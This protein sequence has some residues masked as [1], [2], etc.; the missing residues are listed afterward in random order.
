MNKQKFWYSQKTFED[1][2]KTN[3]NTKEYFIV[4]E[5]NKKHFKILE[6]QN[7]EMFIN[8]LL[9]KKKCYY[10]VFYKPKR[11]LYLDIDHNLNHKLNNQAIFFIGKEMIRLL[12][13]FY[14]THKSTSIHR[15]KTLQLK[16]FYIFN[17]SRNIEHK[18]FTFKLSLHIYSPRII[19]ETHCILQT[20]IKTLKKFMKEL[21]ED[22]TSSSNMYNIALKAFQSIDLDVYRKIQYFRTYNCCKYNEPNSIKK[23]LYPTT[24]LSINNIMKIMNVDKINLD[25]I[26][27]HFESLSNKITNNLCILNN[28]QRTILPSKK[29]KTPTNSSLKTNSYVYDYAFSGKQNKIKW[30]EKRIYDNNECIDISYNCINLNIEYPRLFLSLKN[31]PNDEIEKLNLI[32]KTSN[33][34]IKDKH[35]ILFTNWQKGKKPTIEYL[36]YFNKNNVNHHNH[37][38]LFIKK[39]ANTSKFAIYCD[40][41]KRYFDL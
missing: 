12:T 3:Q 17:S 8:D 1:Y 20:H 4:E 16:D 38:P 5:Y 28:K 35:Q 2:L 14:N 37:T 10:N 27:I 19:Y 40:D 22:F 29:N 6:Y 36:I 9:T 34:K 26:C 31:F 32:L 18:S 15:K 13:N 11:H 41:C 25:D 7:E 23:T 21:N 39:N 33:I 30:K 24:T